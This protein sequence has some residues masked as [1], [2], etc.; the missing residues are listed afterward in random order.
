MARRIHLPYI[1][2]DSCVWVTFFCY[3]AKRNDLRQDVIA[4]EPEEIASR[5]SS[6]LDGHG[7]EHTIAMPTVIYAEVLG[8]IRGKGR[9]T[10]TQQRLVD[11]A[12]EFFQDIDF[13]FIELDEKV[14]QEAQDHI[15]DHGLT[16]IDAAILASA[17]YYELRHVYTCDQKMLRVGNSIPGVSVEEPPES[18]SLNL[19]SPDLDGH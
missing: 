2:I 18:Y 11:E 12:V 8:I 16:G 3:K 9:T 14:V 13:D 19:R 4:T 17:A 15:K 1:V 7:K 6:L 5:V 10:V